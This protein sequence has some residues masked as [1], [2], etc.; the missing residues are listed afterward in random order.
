[1]SSSITREEVYVAHV[2]DLIL[3]VVQLNKFQAN[4]TI[5]DAS[6]ER[7]TLSYKDLNA[8]CEAWAEIKEM[9]GLK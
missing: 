2:G 7:I 3:R 1:M 5:Q 6:G 4:I 8:L 9:G